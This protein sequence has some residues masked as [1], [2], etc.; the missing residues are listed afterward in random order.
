MELAGNGEYTR[1][2]IMELGAMEEHTEP[3]ELPTLVLPV[4]DR[5]GL[6]NQRRLMGDIDRSNYR[7]G[8]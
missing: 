7:N 3:V 4:K 1:A 5:E 2:Q 8:R 6:P